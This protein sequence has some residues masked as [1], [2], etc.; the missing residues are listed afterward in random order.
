MYFFVLVVLINWYIKIIECCSMS[1]YFYLPD[2]N[3]SMWQNPQWMQI[4]PYDNN[5]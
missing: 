1:S 2:V 5:K 4:M 3:C